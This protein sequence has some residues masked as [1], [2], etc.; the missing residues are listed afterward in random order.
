MSLRTRLMLYFS[1]IVVGLVLALVLFINSDN[2]KQVQEYMLHGG[3]YGYQDIVRKAENYYR[4]NGSWDGIDSIAAD[5]Q[6]TMMGGSMNMGKNMNAGPGRDGEFTIVD[7]NLVVVWSSAGNEAGSTMDESVLEYAITLSIARQKEIGYL[8]VSDRPVVQATEV[9]PLIEKLRAVVLRSGLIAGIVA[10]VLAIVLANQLIKPVR[11]LTQAADSLAGG[12][13]S[14]RVQ[15]K[16][17]DEIARLGTSFNA[18]AENLES[19]ES[20]K[21]ALTADIAHELR[22]PLAV[23]KAQLEAMQDGIV[24]ITQENLQ[25]V[26]DQTNFLTRL[27]D[28]LRTLALVD[29]GELPLEMEDVDLLSLISKV[30]ERFKPQAD[31]QKVD[32]DFVNATKTEEIIIKADPDR[33]TQILGNL[34]ANALHHTPADGRI[35]IDITKSGGQVTVS[36]RDHGCG[37]P[38]ADLPH[39]FERFYRGDKSRN[40]QNSGSTGLGLSIARHLARVHGGD[41]TAENAE[42]GGALFVLTLPE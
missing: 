3:M 14:T 6:P 27:V 39:L 15:V 4:I 24:P 22:S 32:L 16:G 17:K 8:I 38:E 7:T 11:L 41:L 19:A 36:V 9:S 2:S 31:Q 34:I 5:F 30:V 1:V 42:G 18:M 29:A 28:D 10:L 35:K 21:K 23:Q 12:K 13:L 40:R 20:R 37:I 26:V 25:T 33:M